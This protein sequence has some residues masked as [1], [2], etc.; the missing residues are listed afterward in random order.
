MPLANPS[1]PV[2]LLTVAMA[3]LAEDH[4]TEV[5]IFVLPGQLP[6][7]N[8]PVALNCCVNPAKTV[9]LE[10]DTQIALRG[11]LVT[12]IFVLPLKGP[13]LAVIMAVP[14]L[15]AVTNPVVAFTLATA[16]FDDDQLSG[17]T[18]V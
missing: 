7:P 2:A 5:V 17:A 12:M 6:L 15:L 8:K 3:I 18:A 11:L 16:E 10:G 4:V 14:G 13:A 1:V 9:A